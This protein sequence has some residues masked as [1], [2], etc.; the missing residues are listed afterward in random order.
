LKNKVFKKK[1]ISLSNELDDMKNKNKILEKQINSLNDNNLLLE[2]EI[3]KSQSFIEKM[4]W[5][6]HHK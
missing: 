2:K 4:M 5:K 6:H 3:I 1:V